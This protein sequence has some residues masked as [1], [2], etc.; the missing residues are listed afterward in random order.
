MAWNPAAH[1]AL[2]A[3]G[4]ISLDTAPPTASALTLAF[5]N[6]TGGDVSIRNTGALTVGSVDGLT[7]S[8]NTGAG[9]IT[10]SATGGALTIAAPVSTGSG[11]INLTASGAGGGEAGRP[12]TVA[13]RPSRVT[14]GRAATSSGCSS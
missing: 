8:S 1:L 6:S 14:R 11:G 12:G 7:T 5:A 4:G 3:A 10:L 9:T 2:H 13:P